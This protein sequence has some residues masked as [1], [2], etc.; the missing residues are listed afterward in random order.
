MRVLV[1]EDNRSIVRALKIGFKQQSIVADFVYDGEDGIK[2]AMHQDYDVV[3][4]DIMLPKVDGITIL[5][6][7]RKKGLRVSVL[8][9]SAKRQV[10]E[11]VEGL[12]A[13]ADDYL[14]KPFALEELCARIRVLGRR[15]H[16]I[17]SS[18]IVIGNIEINID[19]KEMICS[20]KPIS[21]TPVEYQIVECLVLRRGRVVSKSVIHDSLYSVEENVSSNVIEAMI[22]TIRKKM[23][24]IDISTKSFIQTRRGLGYIIE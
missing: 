8:M 12:E 9:L 7:I 1:I 14:V 18:S 6:A 15:K 20:G 13:G 23:T 21:L 16:D 11:R 4:L 2:F 5:K 3:V 10:S 19:R 24:L 17:V 22:S